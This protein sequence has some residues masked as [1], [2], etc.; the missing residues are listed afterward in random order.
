MKILILTK[1][2]YMNKD[3][4]DDRYGRFW[5]I[6][7]ALSSFGH[8]IH[9]LCLSYKKRSEGV[10]KDTVIWESI[11]AGMLKLPGLLKFIRRADHLASKSDII[12]ACSD[13]F[14]GVIAA[15]FSKKHH[16]PMLFDLYDNFEYYLSG[17]LPILKQLY[18]WA[19]R[20]SDLVT[21][22]SQPLQNLLYSYGIKGNSIV[23]EN[24]VKK[25][26]FYPMAQSSCRRSLNL[27]LSA[28]LV[29]TAG[30]LTKNRGIEVL[31]AAFEILSSTLPNL[32][33]V[34]AGPRNVRIPCND[35]IHDMG[36]LPF[37]KVPTFINAL[38][39][40]VI[41]NEDN[42][43]GRYCFPQKAREIMACN[44]PIV[45]AN[46]GSIAALF[47]KNP[48]WLYKTG[49]VTD[50]AKSISNRLKDKS[51][52]Y[53]IIPNWGELARELSDKIKVIER[54]TEKV[55]MQ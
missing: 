34:L 55:I 51:T 29:G 52:D 41:C 3:L 44:V 16:V 42:S 49:S 15:F 13:A 5:E 27:P 2:Q 7:Y 17:R 47:H 26:L 39:V 22:I 1:R 31:F 20:N 10:F 45:A 36:N 33:L 46:I 24:A 54:R 53:V 40:A 25:N 30:A 18:R 19:V 48:E 4:L 21:C 37:E 12:F 23:L 43:F 14:Y 35:R 32:H 38:D 50:L 9:G 8:N 6:P 11:N 28:Q